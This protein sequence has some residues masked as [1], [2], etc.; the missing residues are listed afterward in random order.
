MKICKDGRIW[1]QNNKQAGD[2][3]GIVRHN[4]HIKKGVKGNRNPMYGKHHSVEARKIM[5]EVN[6]G[7]KHHN[8]Q[9]GRHFVDGYVQLMIYP[10][11]P[12]YLMGK[13][14]GLVSR[15]ILE[16]RLVMAQYLN[17]MLLKT[18]QVHHRNGIRDD[19]RIEN[20]E[21][22]PDLGSHTKKMIC[23]KCELRKE[24][25]LLKQEIKELRTTLQLRLKEEV[26]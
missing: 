15:R 26:K 6:T 12:Y 18:E 14:T 22:M 8:W 25:Y 23:G 24:I 20:L 21:L 5:S 1:G 16:H 7:S 3:L 13:K 4:H 10:D 11:N 19:N 9:G 2:H 17:R